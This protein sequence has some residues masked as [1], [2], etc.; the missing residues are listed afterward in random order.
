MGAVLKLERFD[1]D[2][3]AARR[4]VHSAEELQDAYARGLIEGRSQAE[5][6]QVA[7]V[8]AALQALSAELA[9]VSGAI[10]AGSRNAARTLQPLIAALLDGALPQIARARLEAALLTELLQLSEA[11]SPLQAR[12]RCGADLHPFVQACVAEAGI[13]AIVIDADADGPPGTVEAEL[14][15]GTITWDIADVSRQLRDLMQEIM[16]EH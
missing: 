10:S 12:I 9:A 8:Q 11:V 1:H 16:E 3:P 7:L 5:G 2:E 4:E 6:E 14:L 13:E 15:G